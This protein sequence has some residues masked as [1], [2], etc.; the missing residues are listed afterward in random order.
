MAFNILFFGTLLHGPEL[1]SL[2]VYV[3]PFS[4]M[5]TDCGSADAD[6][7]YDPVDDTIYLVG[8]LSSLGRSLD[9]VSTLNPAT[10]KQRFVG[11]VS[12]AFHGS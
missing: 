5:Q 12:D 1:N 11:T 10:G 9:T 2:T 8:G 6:S 4:E 7:C 3:A